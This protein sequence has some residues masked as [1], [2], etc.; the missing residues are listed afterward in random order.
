MDKLKEK[1]E[2]LGVE[3]A[4]G[5]EVQKE[6]KNTEI[7]SF[8]GEM[9]DFSHGDVDAHE[10]IPGSID[11]FHEAY[12]IGSSQAYTEY[13]GDLN[14]REELAERLSKFMNAEI[15]AKDQ[16]I[17]T[18][19]TQGA[20]FLALGSCVT[21]GVKVAIVEP[22]YFANRKLVEFFEG[23]YVAINLD[24]LSNNDCSG[25]NLRKLEEEFRKGAEVFLFSNPN[26]PTGVIYSD[27]ELEKIADLANKY[28]VTVIADELYSRQ[29]FDNREF[30][31]L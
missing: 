25:I 6:N 17:I 21:R 22:D 1:F 12:E 23:E 11:M 29:I 8:D 5:Q 31:S 9:V 2:R 30:T 14:I 7:K 24:Y 27:A 16:L 4:P 13:K 10:P 3:N 18:P 26:N 19:G 20:L 28:N 15:N